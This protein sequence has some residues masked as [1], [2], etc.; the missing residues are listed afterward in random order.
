GAI[1]G[2]P[3]RVALEPKTVVVKVQGDDEPPGTDRHHDL[4]KQHALRVPPPLPF[5][6]GL[7]RSTRAVFDVI[8]HEPA[9]VPMLRPFGLCS[10]LG[11]KPGFDSVTSGSVPCMTRA[12]RRKLDR[13]TP[14]V[15]TESTFG[16][17]RRPARR[18]LIMTQKV[19]TH[20]RSE[21]G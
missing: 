16:G 2:V 15:K 14:S 17:G 4:P 8:L 10:V 11:A 13:Q 6:A 12:H 7:P 19:H 20:A 5:H 3:R 1:G 21:I 18:G 9:A